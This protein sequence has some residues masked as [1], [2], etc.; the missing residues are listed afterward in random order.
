MRNNVINIKHKHAVDLQ[1]RLCAVGIG[2]RL[3]QTVELSVVRVD[4][5]ELLRKADDFR[6]VALGKCV[7]DIGVPVD[8]QR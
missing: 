2:G 5:L 3:K 7:D 6:R 1:G 4:L 8:L